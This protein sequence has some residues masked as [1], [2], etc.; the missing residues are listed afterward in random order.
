MSTHY[1][2]FTRLGAVN[3]ERAPLRTL[4]RTPLLE[5]LLACAGGPA[6]ITDWRA[7]ALRLIAPAA[8]IPGIAAAALFAERGS[9]EGASVFI[10]APVGYIAEM[11]TV[12]LPADG[13]LR[14]QRSEA[15]ALA[16]DFNRVWNGAG[17]RLLAGRFTDL[18]CVFDQEVDA[19]THDPDEVRDR[20]IGGYLPEGSDSA[21]L[22]RLMSEIELW[23]FEHAV[24]RLRSARAEAAVNALWLWGGG[25][26]LTSLPAVDV[27]S[28]GEDP[29]FKALAAGAELPRAAASCVVVVAAELDTAAWPD[30]ESRLRASFAE[31]RAGRIDRLD[32]SAAHRRFSLRGR[33]NWRPWRRRRPW[34]EAFG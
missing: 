23:L 34:W 30:A 14:L 5:R 22:R 2:R 11:S 4:P 32:L 19:A 33:W 29:L 24:N 20:P 27:S 21:R 12:R 10:A 15:D 31:L 1:Y 6:E 13:I 18:Y 9:T 25:A 16:A 26:P 28:V 8:A 3:R 17:V 7:D